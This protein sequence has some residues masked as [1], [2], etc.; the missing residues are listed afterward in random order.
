MKTD[1][2][3]ASPLIALLALMAFVLLGNDPQAP[4]LKGP[5]APVSASQHP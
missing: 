1:L 4:P 5:S 3:L 2:A